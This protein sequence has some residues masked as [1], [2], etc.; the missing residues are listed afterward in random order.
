MGFDL[1]IRAT[2]LLCRDTGKP[3][4]F[5]H[6]NSRNYDLSVATVPAEHRRMMQLRGG[7][8]HAYTTNVF[9]DKNMTDALVGDFLDKFPTWEEARQYDPEC[10]YWDENDHKEFKATLEWLN[11]N[12]FVEYRV[13]WS[14]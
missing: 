12:H 3:Y 10:T 6:D 14:Y 2:F 9:D 1:F 13:Q 5:A 7:F 8:L 4:C 11:A